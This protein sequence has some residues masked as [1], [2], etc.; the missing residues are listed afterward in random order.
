MKSTFKLPYDISGVK[1]AFNIED[2]DIFSTS[3][4]KVYIPSLMCDITKGEP[5]TF[6]TTTYNKPRFLNQGNTPPLTNPVLKE[7]NYMTTDLVR[8]LTINENTTRLSQNTNIKEGSH[9]R[10]EFINGKLDKLLADVSITDITLDYGEDH[11]ELK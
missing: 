7:Q 10:T 1:S 11:G 4:L 3:H 8:G 9:I 6:I 2:A 5:T